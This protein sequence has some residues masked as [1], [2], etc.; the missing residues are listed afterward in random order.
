MCQGAMQLP[1]V[2]TFFSALQSLGTFFPFD[3]FKKKNTSNK[4]KFQNKDKCICFQLLSNRFP[5]NLHRLN[6]GTF[7]GLLASQKLW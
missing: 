5:G 6:F 2:G 7:P 4:F 3:K 1:P